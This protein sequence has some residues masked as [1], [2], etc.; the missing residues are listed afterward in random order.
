MSK[1]LTVFL[2]ML[3]G[4]VLL[5]AQ[6]TRSEIKLTA[7]KVELSGEVKLSWTTPLLS[8]ETTVYELYR[9]KLP[10]STAMLVISTSDTSFVD[11]VPQVVSSVSQY[12]GYYVLAKTGAVTVK[13]NIVIVPLPGVPQVGAFRLVGKVEDGKVKLLWEAP[14]VNAAVEYYLVYGMPIWMSALK[15]IDS[16]T[17][18]FSITDVPLIDFGTKQVFNY[19]VRAKL[20]SGEFLQS[21]AVQL[22][23][24]IKI[25]RDDVKFVSIPN[26]YGQKDVKY[27]YTAKAVSSDSAAVIRYKGWAS[28]GMLTVIDPAFTID[29]VSGIVDWT[30]KARGYYNIVIIARSSKGGEAKQYFT[31]AVSGG[32]GIILGKVT[33][34][35]AVPTPIPNVIIEVFKADTNKALSFAYAARTDNNG[36]YHIAHVDPGVYKIRANAPSGKFQSQWYEGKRE[37]SQANLVSVDDSAKTGPTIVNF[38]LRGGISTHPKVIVKGSVTDTTGLAINNSD[39]RVVFVRAEFALNLSGG[40]SIAAEN[41]RKYFEFNEHGDFRLEGN[42]EFVFKTKTD[43]LGNYKL[44][45]PFG[46]YIAFARAKGYAIEFYNNQSNIFSAD[47]I[48]I[49]S[50]MMPPMDPPINFTLSPL[51]PVV[52]GGIKGSVSDSVKNIPVPARIVAFRDRWRFEDKFKM[53]RAYITDTDSLGFYEFTELLPGT[54]VV[55]ALPLGNYAPAFYSVDTNSRHWKRA[56]KIVV[57]GN[58]VDNIN[59]YVKPLAPSARGYAEIT[60]NVTFSGGNGQINIS[61]SGAF[62]FALRDGAIAGY[63][64]TNISGDY[65]IDGLAP[66]SYSVSVDKTG[67][68]ESASQEVAVTYDNSGSPVSGNAS[69]TLNSVLSVTINSKVQP[70][71]YSLEQNFPNPFNPSTTIKYSLPNNSTVSLKVYNLIGQEVA[72]LINSYQ[73]SGEY[74]ATFNASN[75]SSGVYFYRLKTESFNVVKKMLLIK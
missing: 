73:T 48:L 59:I 34:T 75:L 42:S 14:L 4:I 30:P 8:N 66:G 25:E 72:T 55:M 7:T 50:P 24:E 61:K 64:I 74:S 63:A 22:T 9:A 43:S 21:T 29:S 17:N 19:F 56:T 51:P 70:T 16:T 32:N 68:N 54:Y 71:N 2:L 38:K 60:G 28:P 20:S 18:L 67:F 46:K 31:V 57:N 12:F 44:E 41:L 49:P 37:A 65:T 3:L 40:M 13:S 23:I 53:S 36:N 45:L 47:I 27:S 15:Q 62:V 52:L 11:H 69:F 33:D 5:L 35:L 10:D 39:T 26:P 6:T 1:R 58:S